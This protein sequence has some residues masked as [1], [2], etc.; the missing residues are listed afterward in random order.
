MSDLSNT[1]VIGDDNFQ[2]FVQSVYVDGDLM[3]FGLV[4]RDY[5]LFPVG[6]YAAAPAW[7]LSDMP[8]IP[9]EEY[10]E[11]IREKEAKKSRTS[12]ILRSNNQA[13]RN[14]VSS[15]LGLTANVAPPL[16]EVLTGE[17]S[18]PVKRD[19]KRIWTIIERE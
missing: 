17:L 4:E 18:S 14:W 1:F 19:S 2:Q 9:L 13:F 12:D 10:P 7:S 8:L 11:R 16:A 3:S 5:G 15:I 6:S